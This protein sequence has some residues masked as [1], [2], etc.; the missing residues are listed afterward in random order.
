MLLDV[1]VQLL[2]LALFFH[3]V[4]KFPGG[5]VVIDLSQLIFSIAEDF[6]LIVVIYLYSPAVIDLSVVVLLEYAVSG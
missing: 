1:F 2:Q 6:Q 4:F 3:V 5:A